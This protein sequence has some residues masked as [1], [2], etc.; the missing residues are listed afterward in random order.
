[1]SCSNCYNGCPQIISD[2][3][4]KYTGIDIPVLGIKKGDSLSYVE[5]AIITFLTSTLDGTGIKPNIDEAI[6]CQIVSK[7]LPTCGDLTVVD[8][9]KALIQA[10]CELKT[11]VDGTIADVEEINDFI[12]S[13]EANYDISDCLTDVTSSSGTHDILQAVI[14]RLCAFIRDAEATYVTYSQVE[15]IVQSYLANLPGTS[16]YYTKMV[17]FVAVPFFPTPAILANFSGSGVG[18]GD[19]EKIYFCNGENNTPDLRGRVPVG[20]TDGNMGGSPL[21]PV[22]DPSANPLNPNY[23]SGTLAGANYIY[24]GINQM[25]LHDH[26]ANVTAS[27][28]AE[29]H[30]H[31]TVALGIGSGSLT[32]SRSIASVGDNG[33]YALQ[34]LTLGFGIPVPP[35]VGKTSDETISIDTNVNVTIDPNGGN[36]AHSN[37]QP[38]IGCYYIMY[39]P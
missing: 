16:K 35:T 29:P 39:I 2:Q 23:Q 6:I 38:G 8:F 11:L 24:L 37:V 27:S 9:L 20:L 15:E 26:L 12:A 34:S 3:C 31:F 25:P 10:V 36:E 22:V 32:S 4:V 13:L 28:T 18:S 7:Y 17:P 21:S 5:Q 1:M 19:W 30:S 14:T 33:S